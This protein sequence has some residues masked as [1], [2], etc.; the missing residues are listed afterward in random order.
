[1]LN[2]KSLWLCRGTHSHE[3]F[4]LKTSRL[5]DINNHLGLHQL[6]NPAR[7]YPYHNQTQTNCNIY[8]GSHILESNSDSLPEIGSWDKHDLKGTV[9][10]GTKLIFK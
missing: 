1:M 4:W 3:I 6:K 10:L 2:E 9:S 8:F 5:N 7:L